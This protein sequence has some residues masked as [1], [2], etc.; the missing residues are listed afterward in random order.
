MS[1]RSDARATSDFASL[2]L[3]AIGMSTVA[4]VLSLLMS[5]VMSSIAVPVAVAFCSSEWIAPATAGFV[6]SSAFTTTSAVFLAPGKA[7]VM[8]L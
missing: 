8:R 7:S 4:T 2:P 1:S 3:P 5:V 6:T